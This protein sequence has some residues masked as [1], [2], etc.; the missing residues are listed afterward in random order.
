MVM[1][2]SQYNA[3]PINDKPC[4]IRQIESNRRACLGTQHIYFWDTNAMAYDYILK[5]YHYQC[6]NKN[7]QSHGAKL[8]LHQNYRRGLLKNHLLKHIL[9]TSQ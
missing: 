3:I 4:S 7:E 9:F 8:T 5:Q 6:G 2:I 1:M